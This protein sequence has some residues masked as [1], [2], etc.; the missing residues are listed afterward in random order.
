MRVL[1]W[2]LITCSAALMLAGPTQRSAFAAPPEKP[3]SEGQPAKPVLPG[4][5]DRN[6]HIGPGDV[7][8][9]SVRGLDDLSRQVKL[10]SDGT[11]DFP[12]LGTVAAAGLT[13][14]ELTA[15]LTDGLKKEL[16][17]P[18]VAVSLVDVYVPPK[19]E[20]VV[21]IPKI[22][23]LGAVTNKGELE[24]PEP[25]PLRTFLAQIGPSDKADLANIRVRYP[26]GSA[27][28]ADFS[29]FNLTGKATNDVILKGGEE[30]IILEKP[31]APPVPEAPK[32]EPLR[33]TVLGAVQKP[34]TFE[35][36]L[37]A[38]ILEIIEKAGGVKPAADLEKV[39]VKGA[40]H[41]QTL[42]VNVEKYIDGDVAAGYV[43]QRGDVIIIPEKPL[44][45]LAFGEVG[46]PGEYPV[47]QGERV[48]DVY[49]AA[50]VGMNADPTRTQL[51]RRGKDGKPIYK[52]VN[53]RDIMRGKD[54]GNEELVAGDV[55]FIPPKKSKGGFLNYLAGIASPLWLLRSVTGF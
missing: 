20:M 42:M 30:I 33:L 4:V 34:G 50:G 25:K 17:R 32:P 7:L 37:D 13:V 36:E 47:R 51:I 27:Q 43:G 39:S 28:T 35:I 40:N 21:K 54:K 46:K 12:I 29:E 52:T 45:V 55:L 48:L 41:P 49:L 19:I 15:K 31:E 53:V 11:F 8:E 24:L 22:T 23:V 14:S 18:L 1:A 16:K 38:T 44:K 3:D 5:V 2:Y 26:D 10:F 6:H 9:I